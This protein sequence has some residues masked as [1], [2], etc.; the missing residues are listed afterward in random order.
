MST[1]TVCFVQAFAVRNEMNIKKYA[2]RGIPFVLF[3]T[4]MYNIVTRLSNVFHN[5][6][7]S[8]L[9]QILVGIVVY[10][11]ISAIYI[12]FSDKKIYYRLLHGLK[13][14]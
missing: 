14:E 6:F 10:V 3:G 2:L 8:T 4:V 11:L 1:L 7:I 12:R 5:V 13:K 9:F